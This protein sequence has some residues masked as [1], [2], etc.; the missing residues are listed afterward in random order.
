MRDGIKKLILDQSLPGM[1]K[2][3][4]LSCHIRLLLC[5]INN[6]WIV[7]WF[8]RKRCLYGVKI[9]LLLLINCVI[10]IVSMLKQSH[11]CVLESYFKL[12]FCST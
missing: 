7:E 4:Y 11:H 5:L 1:I 2:F 8:D 6:A 9:K 12:C 10:I 3:C